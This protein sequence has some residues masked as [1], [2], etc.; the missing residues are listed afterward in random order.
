[1]GLMFVSSGLQA[2]TAATAAFV[3]GMTDQGSRI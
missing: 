3:D 1:V 2:V